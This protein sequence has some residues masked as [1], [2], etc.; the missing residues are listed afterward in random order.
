[1]HQNSL[2]PDESRG[3][4]AIATLET[5]LKQRIVIVDGSMGVLIQSYKLSENDFRGKEFALHQ[6]ELKGCNDILCLTNPDFISSLHKSYFDAGA[7]IIETNTFNATAI[8]LADYGLAHR[9]YDINKAG[10]AIARATAD[11]AMQAKPGRP[12]L[13]AGSIGPTNKTASLPYDV[14]RPGLRNTSFDE[15]CKAYAE[16]VRGLL[17]GGVDILL[18]ETV[19]DTLNLKA[20]LFAINLVFTER[21][22]YLPVIASATVVDKSGRTLAGQTVEALFT[23]I[24]HANPFAVGL[25]CSTGPAAMRPYL[26]ELAAIANCY[27]SC[28]PNAGLPNAFGQYDETPEH[29]ANVLAEFAHSGLVNIVGGC[30]GT[31]PEHIRVISDAVKNIE[32]RQKPTIKAATLLC[33]LE[34]LTLQPDSNFIVI[35]ERTNVAGSKRFARLIKEGDYEAAL[36]IARNQVQGGANII[37]VNVD[38]GLLDVPQVMQRFLHYLGAEPDIARLPIMIDSS[39]FAVIEA[40]LKCLQGKGIVN[41]L[42]LK[43]G[44]EK[45]IKQ[46]SIVLHYGAAVVVMAFDERGQAVTCERRIEI[47]SRAYHILTEQVGFAPEDIIFDPNVLSL[48]TGIE[49]HNNYGVAFIESLRQLKQLFPRALLSGGISNVSFALRGNDAIREAF[50]AVFLYHAIEAGLDMGIVNAGQLAIYDEIPSE[51]RELLTDV[52]FNRRSDATERLIIYAQNANLSSRTAK[53]DDAWRQQS[54]TE[55]LKHALI[56]GDDTYIEVDT[57]EAHQTLG[58][59][60]VVIEGPLMAGMSVVG[61]LFGAGKMFLPQVVKSAR[62]MKK[63]VAILEPFMDSAKDRT[64]ARATIVLATVKGDVHDIGKNI[65]GL[66]LA[67]NN[68]RIIDLGIMV[69]TAQ[70]VAAAREHKADIV[71]VSGLI[72]PSLDEM[73]HVAAQLQ[74]EGLSIPLLIGGAATN[75]KHTAVKIAPAYDAVSVHVADASRVSGVVNELLNQS[76]KQGAIDRIR[77][78]QESLRQ[79]FLNNQNLPIIAYSEAQKLAPKLQFNDSTI[80]KPYFLGVKTFTPS[81]REVTEY[82]DWSPLFHAWELKG[83][84]PA[85]L[86]KPDIGPTAR[87][88]FANAQAILEHILHDNLLEA[89]AVY[90][91]FAAQSTGDD[92]I[93]YTD[94]TLTNELLRLHSLRQQTKRGH[95]NLYALADFIAPQSSKLCDYIG[96]F[97]VTT[98]FGVDELALQYKKQQ[99]DYNAILIKVIAERLAEA[100]AEMLHAQAR[101]DC[102]FGRDENL[103]LTDLLHER[104]RGIRPA[105]GYPACPDH[106]E[107]ELLWRLLNVK[108][109]IGLTL[110]ENYAMWPA[111]AVSGLYFN[112]PAARYF[113]L[114]KIGEDQLEAYAKRKNMDIDEVKHWLEPIL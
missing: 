72:T 93:L 86:D 46:A 69:P 10:A 113:T 47:L 35:G 65:V 53:R 70:I 103:S 54:V 27:I 41:S 37:D 51:L 62:V 42:S 11:S 48:A 49:E 108:K 101:R 97:A 80:A 67:C 76:Q 3:Q 104:Y 91:F 52:I 95:V 112:H 45:F 73:V 64:N 5:L 57:N 12:R 44:E 89:R 26:E 83:V 1:M 105:S 43:E 88:L 6:Q 55:R 100:C 22:T 75:K 71:G 114:G 111:A 60:L 14:N 94:D 32:P 84:Y 56:S 82:I 18:P 87:E 106:T 40:G 109:N 15:L 81:L 30:C 58:N 39:D 13:V 79:N 107:K 66:V 99:D 23:S 8:S 96:A 28:I 61:E 19:F 25:N 7:D 20:A 78:A 68:Y 90:G 9:V 38:E 63:A 29:V 50:N 36:E 59:P 110:T 2:N 98:G 34:L 92:I 24:A 17:D 77:Q 102:G 31:T 4:K 16:Q 21:N 33:G 85:I 74:R